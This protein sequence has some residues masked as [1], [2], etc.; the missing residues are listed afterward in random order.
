MSAPNPNSLR[1]FLKWRDASGRVFGGTNADDLGDVAKSATAPVDP[2]VDDMWFD[3]DSDQWKRWNG[4]AWQVATP[5]S[6]AHQGTVRI[7][8]DGNGI[9][10]FGT[11]PVAQRPNI[12]DP[13]GGL[14]TDAQAREAINAILAVLEAYGLTASS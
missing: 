8:V 13:S 12:A 9:G 11:T 4:S 14:T 10:F 6:L 7:Q 2:A 3:T 5:S 1:R